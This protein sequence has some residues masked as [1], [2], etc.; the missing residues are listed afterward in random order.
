MAWITPIGSDPA[1]VDYRLGLAHGCLGEGINDAQLD[2]HTDARER[3]LMWVGSALADLGIQAGSELTPDQFDRARA[4]VNGCHPLTGEQLVTHKKAVP[5]DAKVALAP[6]VRMIE[7]V[8][9]EADVPLDE[10]LTSQRA[11]TMFTRAQN[12]VKRQGEAALLRADH[13][14]QLADAAGLTPDEVWG[15]ETFTHAVSQLTKTFVNPDGSQYQI[16]NR[17]IAGN[18]AYDAT[19]TLDGDLHSIYG[20][21][22]DEGRAE[23]ETIFTDKALEILGCLEDIAAY[24]MR[25]HHG[26]GQTAQTIRGNGFAGWAMFHRTARPVDGAPF[27]DPH[28]HVHLTLA[29]MTRGE[30]GKWSTIASGGRDLMRHAALIDRLLQA[31]VRD[32]LVRRYGVQYRWDDDTGRWR[33]AAVPDEAI[34][35]FS[36]RG[37]G[38]DKALVAMGLSPDEANAAVRRVAASMTREGKGESTTAS[39]QTLGEHWRRELL[40]AHLDPDQ[41]TREF[42]SDPDDQQPHAIPAPSLDELALKL[43]DIESGLTAHMRRFSTLD[44]MVAVTD[45][46]PPDGSVMS[47]ADRAAKVARL[48]DQLL[49]RRGFVKLPTK[50]PGDGPVPTNGERRQLGASHMANTELYTTQDVVDAETIIVAAARASHPD[51]THIRVP[52]ATAQMAASTVEATGGFTLSAEQRR[53]LLRITTSG[54][55]LDT[56]LGPPGS[57]KTTLM[58][59]VRV[60]YESEGLVIAGTTT[61]GV[62]VQTLHAESGIPSRTI[63]QWLWRID[64][65]TGLH[66]VDVLV[67]DEAGMIDDRDRARL[68]TAAAHTGTKIL[69]IGDPK[70]LRGVGVGSSFAVVHS[71]VGGGELRENRRQAD[72]DERAAIAAWRRGDYSEALQSWAERDRVVATETSQEATAAMLATWLDQRQ[73]A[74]DAFTEQRGLLMIA[75]TNEIVNR[76]NDAA[77]ALRAQAG[78]LGHHHTYAVAG[79]Q[80]ITLYEGD[81]VT[82]RVTERS[83][84]PN[85]PPVLNGY[86][87]VIDTIA[88]D[89]TLTVRW[90]RATRGGR[91]VQTRALSPAFVAKGGIR[92]GYALTG[93]TAQGLTV[94]SDGATWPG[95]DGNRRG[96]AVLYDPTGADNPGALV[97]T[98]RHKLSVT[99]FLGRTSVET[100]QDQYLHGVPTTKWERTRR[101]ITKLVD[102]ATA[103][104]TNRNDIPVLVDLGKLDDPSP[105]PAPAPKAGE[106]F[107]TPDDIARKKTLR[108]KNHAA[109]IVRRAKAQALLQQEWGEHPAVHQVVAGPA[110]RTLATWLDRADRAGRNP[111]DL[112]RVINPD[113]MTAPGVRDASRLAAS[114]VK[115]AA[116]ADPAVIARRPKPVTKAQRKIRAAIAEQ[117]HRTAAEVLLREQWDQHPAVDRIL[118]GTAFGALARNLATA[119]AAGHDPRTLLRDIDPDTVIRPRIDNP[120]AYLASRIRTASNAADTGRAQPRLPQARTGQ[121]PAPP[122][123]AEQLDVLVRSYENTYHHLTAHNPPVPAGRS[124]PGDHPQR[125]PRRNASWPSWL[126]EPPTAQGLQGRARSLAAATHTDAQRIR[127]RVIELGQRA[128]RD[129]PAWVDQLGPAPHS[130]A[131]LAR[132][133]ADITTIAA[134]R[135]QH[136]ITGPDPLGA[137]P[138]QP[139]RAYREATHARDRLAAA[140]STAPAAAT[141]IP[142]PTHDAAAAR[143]SGDN[144]PDQ[145]HAPADHTRH[146]AARITE[147]QR[148]S[149]ENQ[150]RE[151]DAIRRGREQQQGRRPGF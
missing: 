5:R 95:P 65:G 73:G 76:L 101:V 63:K 108:A 51:Q 67:L 26:D 39:N 142:S 24:G 64:N 141:A 30:D 10:V 133:I 17:I 118:T 105:R 134:Y 66:G 110:F 52:A 150:Q 7:G 43:Q 31:S 13:A 146:V 38:I 112:V 25:G 122:Q 145:S 18:L 19:L 88:E 8:A 136:H 46:L 78:E 123:A 12:A 115:Q 91:V 96:G 127:A 36:K 56:L 97:A 2:Y 61:Q 124:G 132:Y 54:R 144:H 120:S 60:A 69:E 47:A 23:L 151:R 99:M 85:E 9:R 3:P 131:T 48:T 70:Q 147:Q 109:D 28:W 42:R 125:P 55:A 33:I 59:A 93:H 40:D 119:R 75:A 4:L 68:Y 53:E 143:S 81:Y 130:A 72:I 71:L 126:P 49:R 41:M 15:E 148:L 6:L 29:N 94:G 98:T 27:G 74:P 57:G 34:R 37:A 20:A 11:R 103:T 149:Q 121:P 102:R 140:S 87:G 117:A 79:A 77:Q 86:R 90:Q 116:L 106:R 135:E 128:I 137:P 138:A 107:M 45:L 50:T 89:G 139:S 83:T 84:D 21:M 58:D 35:L 111:A 82:I 104:E 100:N 113:T 22:H 32:V 114:Q 129:R 80:D 44:A 62:T 14:G 92:K 16:D 1:Q